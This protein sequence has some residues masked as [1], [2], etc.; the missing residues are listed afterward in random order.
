MHEISRKKKTV[1]K[2]IFTLL[3]N[4]P[5]VYWRKKKRD[6]CPESLSRSLGCEIITKPKHYYKTYFS[7]RW[8]NNSWSVYLFPSR[9]WLALIQFLHHIYIY[10]YIYSFHFITTIDFLVLSN[11]ERYKHNWYFSRDRYS[12]TIPKRKNVSTELITQPQFKS[13]SF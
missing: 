11:L 13:K 2:W 8:L 10:I 3:C 4:S 1:S 12:L 6:T 9:T 7:S 5:K